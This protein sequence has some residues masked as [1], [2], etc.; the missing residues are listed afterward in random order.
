MKLREKEVKI[1]YINKEKER[2]NLKYKQIK[3]ERY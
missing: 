1:N 2:K 3:K